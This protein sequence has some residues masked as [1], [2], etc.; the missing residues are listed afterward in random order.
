MHINGCARKES[1]IS[2]IGCWRLLVSGDPHSTLS[3]YNANSTNIYNWLACRV[4]VDCR[5]VLYIIL[6][7]LPFPSRS[8]L[9]PKSIET[10]SNSSFPT[11]DGDIRAIPCAD[12]FVHRVWYVSLNHCLMDCQMIERLCSAELTFLNNCDRSRPRV[13]F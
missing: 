2:I 1:N 11:T 6:A 3:S 9:F 4:A 12:C 8:C 13:W 10:W 7:I 5:F